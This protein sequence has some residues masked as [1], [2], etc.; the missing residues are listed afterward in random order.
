M[1][2]SRVRKDFGFTLLEVMVAVALIGV[3]MSLVW[4][5]TSQS[6]RTKDRVEERDTIFHSSDVALRKV[7]D[8]I[9]VAFLTP[10]STTT[11]AAPA[12]GGTAAPAMTPTPTATTATQPFKTFFIGEDRGDQDSVRFSS[13]S[14]IRLVK[15]SKQSDQCKIS[16]EMVP[17]PEEPRRFDLM[18]REDAL[19]DATTEVTGKAFPLAEGIA[20]FNVEY[21]DERKGEWGKEWDTEKGDW[22]DKL[23]VAVRVTLAFPDPDDETKTIPLSTAVMLPLSSGPIEP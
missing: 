16:Y 11:A 10:S 3:I 22:K 13:L 4:S 12:A 1:N 23:P 21:Y 2:I 8:D 15:D 7:A 6:L 20:Q 19:L 14:H 18:R 5:T 17:N 9:A